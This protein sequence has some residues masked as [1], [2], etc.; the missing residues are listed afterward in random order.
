MLPTL[1]DPGE[2]GHVAEDQQAVRAA[3]GVVW[4]PGRVGVEIVVVHR[5]KYG[6]WSLPKGK[7]DPGESWEQA[8][9]REVAE[10]TGQAVELEGQL[11][12]T[13]YLTRVKGDGALRPK[14]VRYWSMRSLGG[15]FTPTAEIDEVRWLP[16]PEAISLLSYEHDRQLVRT[17]L[18]DR[19]T[20]TR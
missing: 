14:L 18:R 15:G 10:E 2:Y 19:A 16:A 1:P 9:V 13:E 5:P 8:A 6:D 7:L 12:Q 3:G 17:F 4:R 11:G 20:G